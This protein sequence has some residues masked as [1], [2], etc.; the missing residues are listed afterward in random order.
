M[1]SVLAYLTFRLTLGWVV[2]PFSQMP[3]W[4]WVRSFKYLHY[5]YP[6]PCPS[7]QLC[8]IRSFCRPFECSESVSQSPNRPIWRK[9]I[10]FTF[11]TG[12]CICCFT[13]LHIPISI[14]LCPLCDCVFTLVWYSSWT[15]VLSLN[16][17][18]V[19]LD[20]RSAA[21]SFIFPLL[22]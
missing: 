3:G 12:M 10:M 13:Y 19:Y 15:T 11:F 7:Q 16:D 20:I 6:Q 21:F 9:S 8:E 1:S 22:W 5:A 17:R 14:L 2:S 18:S 4:Y